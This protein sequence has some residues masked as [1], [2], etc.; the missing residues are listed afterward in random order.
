VGEGVC[1][2]R[3]FSNIANFKKTKT[4]QGKGQP[5][6]VEYKKGVGGGRRQEMIGGR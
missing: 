6:P 2:S 4:K 3:Q 1:G 5:H